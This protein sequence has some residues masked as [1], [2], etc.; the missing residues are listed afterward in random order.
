MEV[1]P[2]PVLLCVGKSRLVSA[3]G[4]KNVSLGIKN[5]NPMNNSVEPSKS[6]SIVTL[7]LSKSVLAS[8]D[9]LKG[10]G[11]DEIC[12]IHHGNEISS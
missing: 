1:S 4:E 10:A 5:I 11:D 3:P 9:F 6:E 2:P 7:V 12:M 8:S